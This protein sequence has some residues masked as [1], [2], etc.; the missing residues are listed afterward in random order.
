MTTNKVPNH[1]IAKDGDSEAPQA[2]GFVLDVVM[3]TVTIAICTAVV[4]LLGFP[5]IPFL[6]VIG[7]S[8]AAWLVRRLVVKP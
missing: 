7:L 1:E 6:V 8:F 2:L 3:L 4:H 5:V